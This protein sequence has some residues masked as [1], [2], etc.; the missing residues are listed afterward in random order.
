MNDHVPGFGEIVRRRRMCRSFRPDPVDDSLIEALVDLASRAP[1]AGKT[2]GWHLLVLRGDETDRFWRHAFP[3]ERRAGF[4]WPGLF[5]APVIALPF[6]DPVAYVERYAEPDKTRTG[7]GEGIEAWPTP[8]WTIDASMALMTLLLGA[9]DAGLGAL[10]FAVFNGEREVRLEL[11]V[12][13]HLQLL[14]AVA[15]GWPSSDAERGVSASRPRRAPSTI[16]HL[17]GW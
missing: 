15:L 13:D 17:G 4:R 9:D 8:Y 10:L 12:P 5:D 14:G 2:Q 7:L 6:A 16:I 3:V 11:G 1:S